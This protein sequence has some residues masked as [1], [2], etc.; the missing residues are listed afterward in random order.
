M[1]TA[2]EQALVRIA[3]LESENKALREELERYK[4]IRVILL[5]NIAIIIHIRKIIPLNSRELNSKASM[6]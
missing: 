6:R 3:K 5:L 4:N 2:L 1:I